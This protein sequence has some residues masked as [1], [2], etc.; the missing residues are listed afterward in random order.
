MAYPWA[1]SDEAD[2]SG[3]SRQLVLPTAAHWAWAAAESTPG[4]D[5]QPGW[6]K[7]EDT[8]PPPDP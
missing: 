2:T 5:C 4:P 3:T 6:L 7:S 8:P 1:G